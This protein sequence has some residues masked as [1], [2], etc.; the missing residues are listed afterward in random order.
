MKNLRYLCVCF[1]VC[2]IYYL[3]GI[4]FQ[5]FQARAPKLTSILCS[6]GKILNGDA[7]IHFLPTSNGYTHNQLYWVHEKIYSNHTLL[8]KPSNFFLKANFYN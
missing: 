5:V 7:V 3:S 6:Q 2:V 8:I 1:H 4:L